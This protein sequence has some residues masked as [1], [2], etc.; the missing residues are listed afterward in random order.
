MT[1]MTSMESVHVPGPMKTKKGK[2]KLSIKYKEVC[3]LRGEVVDYL[4]S[5]AENVDSV[6]FVSPSEYGALRSKIASKLARPN[7]YKDASTAQNILDKT[8][9]SRMTKAANMLGKM[10]Q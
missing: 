8:S 6:E 3:M 1:M 2:S 4:I 9:R 7:L 5:L 10:R